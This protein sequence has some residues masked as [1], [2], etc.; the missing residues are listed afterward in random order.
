MGL[1]YS[2]LLYFKRKLQWDALKA[3]VDISE[4]H[5]P[6]TRIIF[7][8]HELLVPLETWS[9]NNATY[10]YNDPEID[11]HM[12]IYFQEDEAIKDYRHRLFGDDDLRSPPEV[13]QQR[14]VPIGYIYLTI[15]NPSSEFYSGMDSSEYVAFNFGTTGT[16]MSI[17]FYDSNS[18][19]KTFTGLLERVPGV[20]GVFNREDGGGD[21]FWYKGQTLSEEIPDPF[22]TLPEIEE[23]LGLDK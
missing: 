18:I 19:R 23:L 13:V 22:M 6:P 14:Q 21:V 5:Q 1:D 7:P 3:V 10:H 8:D 12:S 4:S 20:C 9:S 15:Y 2:Y 16:R 11:L 17:L